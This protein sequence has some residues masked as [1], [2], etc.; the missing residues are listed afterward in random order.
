MSSSFSLP[1]SFTPVANMTNTIPDSLDFNP[2]E[3]LYSAKGLL[4]REA[5]PQTYFNP[6]FFEFFPGL[7]EFTAQ[8]QPM[9]DNNAFQHPFLYQPYYSV[10]S[11]SS[12]YYRPTEGPTDSSSHESPSYSQPYRPPSPYHGSASPQYKPVSPYYGPA[13]PTYT[14]ISP[15]YRGQPDGYVLPKARPPSSPEQESLSQNHPSSPSPLSS[16]RSSP[17]DRKLPISSSSSYARQELPE[18]TDM[19]SFARYLL[20]ATAASEESNTIFGDSPHCSEALPVNIAEDYFS[21]GFYSPAVSQDTQ[22]LAVSNSLPSHQVS[23]KS[24]NAMESQTTQPLRR[25]PSHR[26]CCQCGTMETSLWR[27]DASGK[28]LCNACKL[29]FKV[30]IFEMIMS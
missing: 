22:G 18:I 21:C 10:T 3:L 12:T 17:Y 29:Y 27:R 25:S 24:S 28:P 5:A 11:N 16:G 7:R 19:D 14:P 1:T 30:H 23:K 13:S 4:H 15:S 2:E 6:D 8:M 26:V 20:G 9:F